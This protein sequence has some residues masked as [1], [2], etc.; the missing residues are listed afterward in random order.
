MLFN[1]ANLGK[2]AYKNTVQEFFLHFILKNSDCM[3]D[4]TQR[5]IL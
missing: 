2:S 3:Y 1:K 5:G 4:T